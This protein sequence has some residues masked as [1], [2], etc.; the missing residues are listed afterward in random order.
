MIMSALFLMILDY[1]CVSLLTSEIP[2][3]TA[4]GKFLNL[5]IY[6]YNNKA[7]SSDGW[8]KWLEILRASE[9]T[10]IWW[11][12]LHLQKLAPT[13]AL[14]RVDVRQ[15]AGHKNNCPISITTWWKTCCSDPA[16]W[17]KSRKKKKYN[18]KTLCSTSRFSIV[19][20]MVRTYEITNI[21][22]NITR[23]LKPDDSNLNGKYRC[24][25]ILMYR[26]FIN[27]V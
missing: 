25:P 12:R 27:R 18:Y 13:P 9:G 19:K 4:L 24:R 15:A 5:C 1:M 22:W 17:D 2:S 8:P 20:T 11:S 7:Q 21:F 23:I 3:P 14:I 26:L 10:L 16:Q 6:M